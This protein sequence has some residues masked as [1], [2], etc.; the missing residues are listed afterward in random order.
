MSYEE[1]LTGIF[2][3]PLRD[4]WGTAYGASIG[5]QMD[6][7]VERYKEATHAKLP[8][9]APSA[10]LDLIGEER[11]LPRGP[12]EADEAHAARLLDAWDIWGGDNTPLTGVGGGAA[13]HLGMLRALE[14]AGIPVGPDGATIVQ[15][16]GRYAQLDAGGN[17]FLGTL[18]DAVHRTDKTGAL[19][20]RPGWTFDGRDN[21]YSIF[22]LVFS[23]GFAVNAGV[24]NGVVERWRP[25]KAL[26]CGAWIL[27]GGALLG[28]PAD[29]SRTL[30]T[31]P[32]L[33]SS[34]MT[35]VPPSWGDDKVIGYSP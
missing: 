15:Q 23:V 18:L 29:P 6:A 16:N 3:P 28:W 24:L 5:R 2:P 30:V 32:A 26:Y 14:A 11:R 31:E 10:G 4:V 25:S 8:Q 21:F 12:G 35:F 17:L 9:F 27:T 1:Y 33:G 22:G 7:I 19:N 20:P 34:S 13:S